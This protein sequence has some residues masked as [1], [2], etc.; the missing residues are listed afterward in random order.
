MLT[1]PILK[2]V[3]PFSHTNEQRFEFNF[4]GQSQAVRNNLV[5]Q[6]VSDNTEVYNQN[7]ET[8]SL[9]HILPPS[10]L[11]NG[12]EYRAR[13]RVGNINNQWSDFSDWIVFWVLAEPTIEITTIDYNNQN[14]VYNQTVMFESTYTHENNELLQSYRYLLYDSNQNLIQSFREQFADGSQPLTQEITS[15][16]NGVLYYLEV[17]TISANGQL[18]TSG[19]VNFRPFYIAPRLFVTLTSENLSEQGAIKISANLIQIIGKLYDQN[20]DEINPLDIEYVDDDWIDLTRPNY[21]KLIFNEGFNILQDDFLMRIWCKN[22]PDN[23]VF[24]K[25]NSAYGR[26]ELVKYNDMIHA[27]KYINNS[28]VVSH[29]ASNELVIN[30]DEE[31][32]IEAKQVNHLIDLLIEKL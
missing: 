13:V 8:F 30:Q 4:S 20:G 12:I 23:M 7:Q 3:I 31:F 16:E 17:K 27:F 5:I 9:R 6:K 24:L 1:R 26:I 25:L 22:I 29:F 18:G 14:R 2:S 11:Q 15:L 28:N 21:D 10:T 19:K 32:I